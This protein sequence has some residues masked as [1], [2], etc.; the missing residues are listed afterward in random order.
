MKRSF[1][2][3]VAL[4]L[5]VALPLYASHG[6]GGGG[7]GHV[8][9]GHM[10]GGHVGGGHM[11]GG[12]VGGF[13]GGHVGGFSG[14]HIS[15]GHMGG[16][17]NFGGAQHF[18]GTQ[19]MGGSVQHF[20]G[21]TQHF[22]GVQ[23]HGIQS[24][25]MN[26][27]AIHNNAIRSGNMNSLGNHSSPLGN[28]VI[29]NGQ[30]L[31]QLNAPFYQHHGNH[32]GSS[33]GN[34]TLGNN[35]IRN[36]HVNSVLSNNAHHGSQFLQ[37]HG[38]QTNALH[39]ANTGLRNSNLASLGNAQHHGSQFLHNHG[40]NTGALNKGPTG[41]G[42]HNQFVN[43]SNN[44]HS[45][46]LAHH[47]P[48]GNLNLG[49]HHSAV[50]NSGLNHVHQGTGN[51]HTGTYV[52]NTLMQN[53][54]YAHTH[55]GLNGNGNW[56]GSGNWN[57]NWSHH[58]HNYGGYGYR[59]GGYGG[60]YPSFFGFGLGFGRFG[61]GLG[62]GYGYGWGG[63]GLFGFRRWGCFAYNPCCYY[64]GYGYG[65]PYYGY[66][67]Y[68][69]GNYGYGYGYP[70]YASLSPGLM[71]YGYGAT[72]APPGA[73]TAI[74]T[75]TDALPTITPATPDPNQV[76]SSDTPSAVAAAL[77]TAEQ[78]AEIGETAFKARDYKS[79]VRAWRHGLID[80][81]DNGVLVLMLSQGLFASGN[82]NEA[83]GATQFGM[84]LLAQD[85]WETVVKNY[86]E[87]Y[88][89]VDDYTNQLRALEKAAREKPD[90]PSLRFLLGY[91]YGFLGYPKEAVQQLEK[92][93]NLAPEDETAQKL[94]DLL[95]DKLPK[96][97]NKKET[98]PAPAKPPGTNTLPPAPPPALNTDTVP[99]TP[100]KPDG[101]N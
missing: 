39:N 49:N 75:A 53:F 34:N 91:H 9:G 2:T 38:T 66:G 26:N 21:S 24:G 52:H 8:G 73:A 3:A 64:G 92:C 31:H 68:G 5:S 83:A 54:N 22:G 56:N 43:L 67:G 17:Q 23:N 45:A 42:V 12:H 35:A 51:N 101:G 76:A 94:L 84:Q 14:G 81:P 72:Y 11:G 48:G 79:A 57:G 13:S 70:A 96:D 20:G 15:S 30:Q 18:G 41:Q 69:Y 37:H 16:A 63:Y 61:Y 6:H 62:Y 71:G 28:N 87:L 33:L 88:G 82:F 59:W 80:D 99:P 27:G 74:I 4:T 25:V 50:G 7:G 86:R 85:K 47:N 44:N 55:H 100:K 1:F 19:H 65:Y 98:P 58:H 29:H 46:F 40:T 10:G 36:N 89:K 90:E 97:P 93:T 77:P 60:Y 32:V 78:Y 95:S